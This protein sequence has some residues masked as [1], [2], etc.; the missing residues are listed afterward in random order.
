MMIANVKPRRNGNLATVKEKGG[1]GADWRLTPD[2][3]P[4]LLNQGNSHR[5]NQRFRWGQ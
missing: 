4:R 5:L 1:S 2:P 3:H